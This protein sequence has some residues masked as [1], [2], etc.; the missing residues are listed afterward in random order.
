MLAFPPPPG[1]SAWRQVTAAS[2]S[3]E[4]VALRLM[5]TGEPEAVAAFLQARLDT[6]GKEDKAQ[7]CVGCRAAG[8]PGICCKGWRQQAAAQRAQ[9][10]RYRGGREWR[11][12][13]GRCGVQ[14]SAATLAG[15][16]GTAMLCACVQV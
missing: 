13:A 10:V 4:E 9:Q 6:L 1:V 16:C 2:P 15:S 11:W 8:L 12:Q 3:F 14:M 5:E 7:V